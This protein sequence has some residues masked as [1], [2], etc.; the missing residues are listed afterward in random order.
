[1][2]VAVAVQVAAFGLSALLALLRFPGALRGRNRGM[3]TCMVLIA[4]AMALSLPVFYNAVDALLGGRNLTNLVLRLALYAVFVI[5]GVKA[6]AAFGAPRAGKLIVG[7]IGLV[8]LGLTVGLTVYLFAASELPVSSAGLM[9]YDDQRSV[10]LYAS[11]GRLYP[12]YVAACI[13]L[14]A[15]AAA[16]N[17]RLKPLHR[18]GAGLVGSGLVIVVI[19]CALIELFFI[20]VFGLLL[21]FT[22]VILVTLGLTVMWVSH[23]R[24]RRR[25]SRN[26]LAE[27]YQNVS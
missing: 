18:L 24:Q 21:P 3:F 2:T 6:A 8:V 5:L 14:P 22:A 1:M 17:T 9:I 13:C 15:L 7:P 20:G 19:F 10:Q 11:V 27:S 16:A 25:P 4:L 26:L 23:L 12:G